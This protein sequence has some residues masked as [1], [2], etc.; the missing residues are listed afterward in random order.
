MSQVMSKKAY[1][2]LMLR[3]AKELHD[4]GVTENMRKIV[5]AQYS[6]TPNLASC[7]SCEAVKKFYYQFEEHSIEAT[8]EIKLSLRKIKS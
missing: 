1:E 6:R 7:G 8:Q 2:E 5:E 4:I 3:F